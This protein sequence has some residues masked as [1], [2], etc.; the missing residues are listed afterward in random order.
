MYKITITNLDH[1]E[2]AEPQDSETIITPQAILAY[3]H[4]DRGKLLT[5]G[6][7]LPDAAT[8]RE[9]AP[10]AAFACSTINALISLLTRI[11]PEA[12]PRL[13]HNLLPLL[14][15]WQQ[16]VKSQIALQKGQENE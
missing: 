5:A 1:P 4:A 7:S 3:D 13:T 12:S 6:F 8:H 9:A 10:L 16:E 15:L 11:P 14:K 2:D